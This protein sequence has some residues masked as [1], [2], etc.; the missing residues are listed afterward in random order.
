LVV[1]VVGEADGDWSI[2]VPYW[3]KA[4]T[5]SKI[6]LPYLEWW[7]KQLIL[8]NRGIIVDARGIGDEPPIRMD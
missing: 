8:V 2:L 6:L 7:D 3:D 4:A 1:I 5:L